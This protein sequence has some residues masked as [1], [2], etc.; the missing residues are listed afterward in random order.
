[1]TPKR[2]PSVEI[3]DTTLRDGGQGLGINFSLEDKLRISKSLDALGVHFI[4]GGWPDSNRTDGEYFK[5]VSSLNLKKS[6]VAAFGRTRGKGVSC[7]KDVTIQALLKADTEVVTIFGKS[8]DAHAKHVLKVSLDEN[9]SMIADSIKYLKKQG[10]YVIFDAEHFFDGYRNAPEYAM[11][12]LKAAKDSGVDRIVLCDTNGGSLPGFVSDAVVECVKTLNIPIGIHAHND[13]ELAVANSLIAVESGATQVHGTLNGYGERC[14]NANLCSIIPNLVLKMGI[15]TLPESKLKDLTDVAR[16]TGELLNRPLPENLPYVGR[17][18][19]THKGGTH[20][21]AMRKLKGSYEHIEP[22]L[23]GNETRTVVSDV[24]GRSNVIHLAQSI[25]IDLSSNP[26]AV[27]NILGELKELGYG[28][29]QFEGAEGSFE[30]IVRRH[31]GAMRSFFELEGFRV[32]VDRRKGS[33]IFSEAT[34]KVRVGHETESSVGEG[35]GPVDALNSALR[36]ALERFYPGLEE[37]RLT[38]YKV[39]VL[40]ETAGTAAKVRV[41]ISSRD[42]K[43][44]WGTVGVSENVIQ[45]SWKALTDSIKYKLLKDGAKAVD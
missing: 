39:R 17:A 16:F 35:N 14:G 22:G 15:K 36:K 45:A 7:N 21:D 6:R 34:I 40:D 2:K 8:W 24:A 38:D 11:R 20:M 33:E 12:V 13:S 37:M 31:T 26:E 27:K 43:A 1:M 44:V 19:F 30:L 5:K 18:A 28:G 9:I 32:V 23:V 29:Y 3:Y 41:L 25:G 42:K 4:E 10:R